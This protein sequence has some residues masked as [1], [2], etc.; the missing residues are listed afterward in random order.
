MKKL[1]YLLTAIVAGFSATV[2]NAAVELTG[3]ADVAYVNDQAGNGIVAIGSGVV[4]SMS[5]ETANGIAISAGMSQTVD[6]D[7]ES[8]AAN[9]GGQSVTFKTNGATIVVGDIELGDTPGS[10][11]GVVGN[12]AADVGGLDTDVHTGFADDDGAGVSLSTS[13]GAAT[14]GIGYI[15]EDDG[16][17]RAD[18]DAAAAETMSAVSISMP[19]GNY[20]LTAGF[21]D[22]ASGEQAS[23]ATVA[24]T[25]GGGTLTVG[26]SQQALLATSDGTAADL[27]VAGDSTVVGATYSMSLDAD[28]TL[29]VG[30]QNA[31]DADSDSA[32]QGDFSISR[33]LG[34]GAS[35][36][37]DLRTL[38]GDTDADGSSFAFGT[39]VS[40]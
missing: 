14:L 27:A 13:V 7:A 36:Y 21:A 37:L 11:G 2:A 28:T 18:I 10:I 17:S 39:A 34:G 31:K 12:A 25:I 5:T 4:F 6:Q 8:A 16:N 35:V 38:S 3:S 26:Y 33:S 19:F 20:T 22:H 24:A 30:Y 29:K 1:T 9:G 23:G 15:F 32:T 40:F